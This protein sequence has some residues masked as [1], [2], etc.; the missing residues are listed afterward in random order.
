MDAHGFGSHRWRNNMT[1]AQINKEREDLLS[2]LRPQIKTILRSRPG[3]MS[4]PTI[5]FCLR[6]E[7]VDRGQPQPDVNT[8]D[9]RDAVAEMIDNREAEFTI[10]REVRLIGR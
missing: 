10:S 6:Q 7:A 8:F 9:V 5:E 4:L 3:P 1:L 2:R